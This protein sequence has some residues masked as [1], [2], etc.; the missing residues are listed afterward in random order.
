[1]FHNQRRPPDPKQIKLDATEGR[2][3]L[4][5]LDW[6]RLRLS[7]NVEG[8]IRN[9]NLSREGQ[10][11]YA[12]IQTQGAE[13]LASPELRV[14]LGIDLGVTAIAATSEGLVIKPLSALKTCRSRT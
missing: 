2:L 5:K 3:Q 10:R 14:A 1:M 13:V 8:E 7:R 6:L 11:W 12:S 4:P 9:V